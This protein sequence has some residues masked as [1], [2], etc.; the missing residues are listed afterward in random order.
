MCADMTLEEWMTD[1]LVSNDELARLIGVHRSA[2]SRYRNRKRIPTPD[3][4][5]AVVKATQGAVMPN[6]WIVR[7]AE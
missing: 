1:R 7:V 4:Q 6:D 3:V 2:I 5:R